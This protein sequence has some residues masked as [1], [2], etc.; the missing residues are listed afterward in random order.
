MWQA[1]PSKC[2]I[3]PFVRPASAGAA[4]AT[5]GAAA[6]APNEPN[7]PLMPAL[8]LFS[9]SNRE[10]RMEVDN[11]DDRKRKNGQHLPAVR[12]EVLA[13]EIGKRPR[14]PAT[15]LATRRSRG[16]GLGIET[17]APAFGA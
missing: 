4:R 11:G 9:N 10:A 12:N 17:R 2:S 7:R 3:L 8:R 6:C 16:P 14:C 1:P 13:R 15:R 5:H